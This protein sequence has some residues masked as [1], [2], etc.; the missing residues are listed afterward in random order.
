[1]HEETVMND[2]RHTG[3]EAELKYLEEL[4]TALRRKI[5]EVVQVVV[6][7]RRQVR[8]CVACLKILNQ[9]LLKLHCRRAQLRDSLR[10][11][12]MIVRAVRRVREFLMRRRAA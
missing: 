11:A 3:S 12:G 10:P 4:E 1:L 5:Q 6:R 9:E 7:A 2:L 8:H